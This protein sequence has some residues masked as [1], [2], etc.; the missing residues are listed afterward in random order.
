MVSVT[1]RLAWITDTAWT[2]Q[3]GTIRTITC[4]VVLVVGQLLTSTGCRLRQVEHIQTTAIRTVLTLTHMLAW[5]TR[6]K[7]NTRMVTISNRDNE[8]H[9]QHIL[10]AFPSLPLL[11]F[12]PFFVDFICSFS[13]P[14]IRSLS[15]RRI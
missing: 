13:R 8:Q 15:F 9:N 11:F 2:L 3:L 14:L 7:V 4:M 1:I 12:D 5:F 6:N 10:F